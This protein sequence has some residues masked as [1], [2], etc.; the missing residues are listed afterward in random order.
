MRPLGELLRRAARRGGNLGML[1]W[2]RHVLGRRY[3]EKRIY[4]YRLVLDADDPGISRQLIRLGERELE[5]KFILER[6]L[7]P[8]MRVFDLGANI[9]Y[10]T[11]MMARRVGPT[12]RVYAVEPVPRNFELLSRNVGRNGLAERTELEQIA[13]AGSD[14][15]KALLISEKSNWHSFQPPA[16]DPGV[17]WKRSY[18]RKMIGSLPVKARALQQLAWIS[19]DSRSRSSGRCSAC[20]WSSHEICASSSRP[21]PSSIIQAT[22]CA[23]SWKR[24]AA[25]ATRSST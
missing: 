5:Q 4:D 6:E 17:P 1:A 22:N 19:R 14:G 20:P 16:I 23:P 7:K 8:G 15:E 18:A 10:Y 3:F 9:G 13:I 11:V 2:Q 12:G 24:S 25:T 21:T